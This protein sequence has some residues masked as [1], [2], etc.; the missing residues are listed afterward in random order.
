MKNINLKLNPEKISLILVIIVV[1]LVG[2]TFL[3]TNKVEDSESQI[4]ELQASLSKKPSTPPAEKNSLKFKIP[5]KKFCETAEP[6]KSINFDEK[7]TY[8]LIIPGNDPQKGNYALEKNNIIL[9]P[10]K[11]SQQ[12]LIIKAW[13]D[14]NNVIEFSL[15]GRTYSSSSCLTPEQEAQE[16]EKAEQLIK[17]KEKFEQEKA[18]V[19]AAEHEKIEKERTEKERLDKERIEQLAQKIEQMEKD[20]LKA[21]QDKLAKEK[22]EQERLEK[23]RLAKE[24]EEQERL[25]KER[26]AKEKEEQERKAR[27]AKP[28]TPPG[29]DETKTSSPEAEELK[30]LQ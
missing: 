24:K 22:E 14:N 29:A 15:E 23:E 30:S 10:S 13:D 18:A 11:N 2:Y 7:K 9:T 4:K 27:E 28:V 1:G 16:K 17:E 19:A 3:L 21:E 6:N 12:I 26:L 5:A 8:E 20:K 25:E